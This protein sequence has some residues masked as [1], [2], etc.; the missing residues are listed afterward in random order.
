MDFNKLVLANNC[1]FLVKVF[2]NVLGGILDWEDHEPWHTSKVTAV[3][4]HEP[5]VSFDICYENSISYEYLL[6]VDVEVTDEFTEKVV[7]KDT[8]Q[9]RFPKFHRSGFIFRTSARNS[10]KYRTPYIKA[11]IDTCAYIYDDWCILKCNGYNNLRFMLGDEDKTESI[12]TY[13]DGVKVKVTASELDW[14]LHELC[15]ECT[16]KLSLLMNKDV[17]SVLNYDWYKEIKYF[18]D[19]DTEI[20]RLKERTPLDYKFCTVVD[21]L[22]DS[23][24][25]KARSEWK[26][27]NYDWMRHGKLYPS[28]IQKII[29]NIFSVGAW[30]GVI[31]AD[32]TN[33]LTTVMQT[34]KVYFFKSNGQKTELDFNPSFIGTI[35]PVDTPET[36]LINKKNEKALGATFIN[37]KANIDVYDKTWQKVTIPI[38]KFY[39]SKVLTSD[40][41]NYSDKTIKPNMQLTC[42][43]GLHG[44]RVIINDISEV[45]YYETEPYNRLSAAVS[46]IPG[47]NECDQIKASI[48]AKMLGQATTCSGSQRSIVC[49]GLESTIFEKSDN[50]IKAEMEGIVTSVSDSKV[51]ITLSDGTQRIISQ[52]ARRISDGT[53]KSWIPRVNVGDNVTYDTVV[54][55][56]KEFIG[57]EFAPYV[58]LNT[59]LMNYKGYDYLDGVILFESAIRKCAIER[60]GKTSISIN[61][62]LNYLFNID[63]MREQFNIGNTE[64]DT[65]NNLDSS[66]VVKIGSKIESGDLLY[67]FAKSK[68]PKNPIQ[69]LILEAN[70]GILEPVFYQVPYGVKDGVV[71]KITLYVL[72]DYANSPKVTTLIDHIIK[73][74]GKVIYLSGTLDTVGDEIGGIASLEIDY[75]YMDYPKIG[76]KFTNR[77]ASKA[78][79]SYI[80]SDEEAPVDE[81]GRKIEC[82][83]PPDTG[84]KRKNIAVQVQEI[85][86]GKLATMSYEKAVKLQKDKN[87]DEIRKIISVITL[88][89]DALN[90]TDDDV[91]NYIESTSDIQAFRIVKPA[92]D[93]KYSSRAVSNMFKALGIK[94]KTKVY[95][96]EYGKWTRQE[97]V[98]G[99]SSIMRLHFIVQ[100]RAKATSGLP[101]S[102]DH[103]IGGYGSSRES[104]QSISDMTMWALM[105]H[106]EMDLY[107]HLTGNVR[108]KFK[109]DFISQLALIGLELRKDGKSLTV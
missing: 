2:N 101:E 6:D 90:M 31:T 105:A 51:T 72:K 54:L 18:F 67:M 35:C 71:T 77:W 1:E 15:Q 69:E 38:G 99:V 25:T 33:S 9:V 37:G 28:A 47:V 70:P 22:S 10:P 45:D 21:L 102:S 103:F 43:Y 55:Q 29:N 104:G 86:L 92:I 57:N 56:T 93:F 84:W 107:D 76:D 8:L 87:Y 83:M 81:Y 7:Y 40:L 14:S 58:N 11:K 97:V 23:F 64:E 12:Y 34:D 75:K 41:I 78:T 106:N 26:Q 42:K 5:N 95:L 4:Y 74:G 19:D 46:L 27:R 16:D 66:G 39:R 89:K 44:D 36:N 80:G 30:A 98:T 94:E 65:F 59:A 3:R 17:P 24:R 13:E 85:E 100:D 32:E 52:S 88:S 49:T 82:I 53:V 108:Q 73:I 50:V 48:G 61:P 91:D 20:A 60:I 63:S 109:N 96:P 79:I 68:T 62:R